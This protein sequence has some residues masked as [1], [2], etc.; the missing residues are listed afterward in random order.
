M[1]PR[2]LR[3]CAP[4]SSANPAY[5]MIFAD[6]ERRVGRA[7]AEFHSFEEVAEIYEVLARGPRRFPD[8]SFPT[9]FLRGPCAGR[10][11]RRNVR[12][13]LIVAIRSDGSESTM[14]EASDRLDRAGVSHFAYAARDG[15]GFV[16]VANAIARTEPQ[17]FEAACEMAEIAGLHLFDARGRARVLPLPAAPPAREFVGSVGEGAPR[18]QH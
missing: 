1:S 7:P 4:I 17:L 8:R 5:L 9:S 3:D 11:R 13:P 12:F 15:R 6:D 2:T 18:T 10:P 14:F 16:I